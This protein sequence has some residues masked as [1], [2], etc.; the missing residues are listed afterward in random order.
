[1]IDTHNNGKALMKI[2]RADSDTYSITL[3]YEH[4]GEL[5]LTA[6]E[7]GFYAGLMALAKNNP[8]VREQLE[9]EAFHLDEI[10][11]KKYFMF[12]NIAW[13]TL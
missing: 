9:W 1:M 4:K 13:S 10:S 2:K 11:A 12:V 8:S 3:Q 6:K 5:A 7:A